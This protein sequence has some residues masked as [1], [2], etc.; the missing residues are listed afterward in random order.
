MEN[1]PLSFCYFVTQWILILDLFLKHIR[2]NGYPLIGGS[3]HGASEAILF[4][5]P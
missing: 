3:N 5:R 2:E 1:R 4:R